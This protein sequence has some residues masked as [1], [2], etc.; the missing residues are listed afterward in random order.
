LIESQPEALHPV[1][2]QIIEGAK[3]QSAV[4]A[5]EALYRLA[6]LRRESEAAWTKIDL[7]ALPTIPAIYTISEVTADPIRLNSNLGTYTNFVNLLDLAAIAVPSGM[8]EDGLPSSLTLIAPSGSDAYLA[9]I[10]AAL[11][12]AS[13]QALGM[14][15]LG[16]PPLPLRAKPG[17]IELAVVGAHLSGMP[18][19]RELVALGAS[20]LRK[21]ETTNDYRLYALPDST[22]P[23]PGLLKVAADTGSAIAAEIWAL[24]ADSFGLFVSRI[25]P[26]LGIGTLAFA[27]G[28]SAKGFLAEAEALRQAEDVSHFGSWRAYMAARA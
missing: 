25:P 1:T 17:Q 12:A 18:L 24:D 16:H 23:K 14:T 27:D 11:H 6:S 15:G 21:V 7:L 13:G 26:P 20:F 3:G 19:N 2:R 22:P 28:T 8:R 9:G 10:G 4:A 5:F